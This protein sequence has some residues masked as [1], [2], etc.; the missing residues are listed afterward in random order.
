LS[1]PIRVLLVEDNADISAN[2]YDFLEAHGLQMDAARNGESALRLAALEP[3]DVF[4][5]DL[6]LPGIDG[7]EVCRRLREDLGVNAPVLMLTARDTLTDKLTG[8]DAGADDYLVKPF[9]LE[10]LEARIRALHRRR[11]APAGGGPLQV[12]DLS[13][14]PDTLHVE[15]AG[16]PIHLNPTGLK[17]LAI[18]MRERHRVVT[19]AELERGVWGDSPPESDAL[20]THMASLRAAI[21]KPFDRPLL[22][23]VHGIGYRLVDPDGL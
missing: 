18:L 21:D 14:D 7:L 16:R 1:T 22:Q 4:I 8:F 15:R 20:R 10:E 13:F 17:L 19:R 12:A 6:G 23:T 5:L 3:Y 2:I 11:Q 9:A